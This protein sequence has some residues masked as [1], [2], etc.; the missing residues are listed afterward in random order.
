MRPDLI[1][2]TDI[3]EYRQHFIEN[4]CD[5]SSP[6]QT[7]DGIQVYFY[8]DMFDHA[9]FES[10]DR[11]GSKDVFSTKRA[12]RI[13]WIKS[14]LQ[15]EYAELYEGYDSKSK[16]CDNSRRV[17]IITEDDYVVIIRFT[18]GIKAKFV[19]AYV[20]DSGHTATKIRT[21]PKWTKKEK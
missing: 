18:K 11:R 8:S 7:F 14:V 10:S 1:S 2:Y 4:Y 6:T 17:A 20:A 5:A 9:F 19:T 21:S 12:E 16:T 13:D 3:E 15:D